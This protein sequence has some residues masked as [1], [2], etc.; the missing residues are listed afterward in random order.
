MSVRH[1]V[2]LLGHEPCGS[3]VTT[4]RFSRPDGYEF[5]AGQWLTLT[6]ETADGKE[7]KTFSICSAPSDDYLE[8]TTRL[9]GSSFKKALAALSPGDRAVIAGPGGRLALAPE[10]RDLCFLAGGVGIT[11]VRS[12]LRDAAYR[13]RVFADALLL[14]G[15]RDA[16]C[17]P[18]A[19]EF[20]LMAPHG[21]RVA[22]C[23]ENPPQ[24]WS[25]AFGFITAQMV[26]ELLPDRDPVTFYV[27]GPP[28]M[29]SAMENVLDELGIPDEQRRVER[30]G[31]PAHHVSRT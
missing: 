24:G 16:T 14:Y 20:E 28:V 22:L 30:F 10:A 23:F 6:L 4:V 5:A 2:L 11:P 13:G 8:V 26:R 18:F 25:G 27:T 15:N 29:V 19:E 21:V 31:P 3:D 9:S 12:M 7:T 17:V 1:E